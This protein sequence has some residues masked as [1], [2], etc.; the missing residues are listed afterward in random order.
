MKWKLDRHDGILLVLAAMGIALF[1]VLY[2][3]VFPE[4]LMSEGLGK[5]EILEK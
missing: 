5:A 2:P 3:R 4:S 1:L